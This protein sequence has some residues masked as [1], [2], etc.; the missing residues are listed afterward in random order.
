MQNVRKEIFQILIIIYCNWGGHEQVQVKCGLQYMDFEG[1]ADGRSIK[2][3][4]AHVA[5]IK[6]V[7]DCSQSFGLLLY[8]Q[9]WQALKPSD[10]GLQKGQSGMRWSP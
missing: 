5:P 8:L 6:L 2:N 7:S 10:P 4:L 1:R 9:P 3:M